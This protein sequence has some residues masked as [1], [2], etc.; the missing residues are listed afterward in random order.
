VLSQPLHSNIHNYSQSFCFISLEG[1]F[2]FYLQNS[3]DY[4]SQNAQGKKGSWRLL[5][6]IFFVLLHVHSQVLPLRRNILLRRNIG[7]RD[8]ED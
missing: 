8:A 7:L 6:L 3:H 1:L 4:F 5:E 2:L